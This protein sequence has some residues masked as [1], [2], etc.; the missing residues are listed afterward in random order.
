MP[1]SRLWMDACPSSFRRSTPGCR[2]S[3]S[4]WPTSRTSSGLTVTRPPDRLGEREGDAG[5]GDQVVAADAAPGRGAEEGDDFGDLFRGDDRARRA[6]LGF[7]GLPAAALAPV[8]P[9]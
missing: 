4:A 1:A 7:E 6:V 8:A 9:E 2:Y 5:V 3:K